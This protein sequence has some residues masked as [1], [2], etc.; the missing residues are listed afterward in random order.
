MTQ[1]HDRLLEEI[2]TL[3]LEEKIDL[4]L[5]LENRDSQTNRRAHTRF[6][7]FTEVSYSDEQSRIYQEFVRDISS[8]GMFIETTQPLQQGQTLYVRMSIPGLDQEVRVP[9]E[10]VRSHPEGMGVQF[11]HPLRFLKRLFKPTLGLT[12]HRISPLSQAKALLKERL[13]PQVLQSYNGHKKRLQELLQ[14]V[15][16]LRHHG[17]SR[18]CPVCESWISRFQPLYTRNP[19]RPEA[20]CPVCQ[21]LERHRLDWLFFREKTDLFDTSSKRLLHVAPEQM[22]EKRFSQIS[23]L[24]SMT[25]D[26]KERASDVRTDLTA[27]PFR[28]NTFDVI[29]C[30]H[31]L[32]HILDDRQA[33]RELHRVLKPQGWAVLQ[34]PITARKTLEDL[35]VTDPILRTKLFG[36]HDHVRRY[37]LD[38]RDRLESAQ[39]QTTI[40]EAA[41][42]VE[43]TNCLVQMGIQ[44]QRKVFYCTKA[45][46][47]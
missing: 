32:E 20:R 6:P 41:D 9:A 25:V 33:I 34:V 27:L 29:Y 14:P 8:T 7:F 35:T 22:F 11:K 36:Q 46:A 43:D 39:L 24:S 31:V 44:A 16:R 3:T 12:F 28:S 17:Q 5:A 26:L 37:G 38:F 21:S 30:S 42:I 23:S 45:Y 19:P 1:L 15:N 2:S 10:V 4:L 47:H 40:Y 13:S 18:F